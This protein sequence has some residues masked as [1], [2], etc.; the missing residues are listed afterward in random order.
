MS[1]VRESVMHSPPL[2]PMAS[3]LALT[4]AV[5]TMSLDMIAIIRRNSGNCA[6]QA[7]SANTT[8]LAFTWPLAVCTTGCLPRCRWVNGDFSKICTP[9]FSAT[10]RRPRAS[11]A[12]CT[13][14]ALGS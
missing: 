3:S 1:T 2:K 14:A 8:W 6:P 13:V 10:R 5:A 9:S 7:L 11:M 12:G 4:G